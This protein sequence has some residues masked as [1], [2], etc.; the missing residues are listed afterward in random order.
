MVRTAHSDRRR[1]GRPNLPQQSVVFLRVLVPE[2]GALLDEVRDARGVEAR[3]LRRGGRVLNIT[4]FLPSQIVDVTA[5]H[6]D[7]AGIRQ[8]ANVASG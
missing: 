3:W 6:S 1:H 5:G 8:L 7:C 2:E 4:H